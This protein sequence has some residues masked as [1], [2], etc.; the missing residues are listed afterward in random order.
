MS[1]S[2]TISISTGPTASRRGLIVTSALGSTTTAPT[3]V[4]TASPATRIRPRAIRPLGRSG[5][6]RRPTTGIEPLVPYPRAASSD[7][8]PSSA[9][10]GSPVLLDPGRPVPDAGGGDVLP[11]SGAPALLAPDRAELAA[12]AP[13]VGAPEGSPD[14]APARS[15]PSA[16]ADSN[17][18]TLANTGRPADAASARVEPSGATIEIRR[19]RSEASRASNRKLIR[20]VASREPCGSTI[21]TQPGGADRIRP[22]AD[23]ISS[24]TS[25]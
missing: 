4:T 17:S 14:G 6:R 24:S 11:A 22:A 21:A 10:R 5:L 16:A 18:V 13:E 12:E 19:P 23:V 7:P 1:G 20:E 8:R 15:M 25:R 3:P 2:A 9:R